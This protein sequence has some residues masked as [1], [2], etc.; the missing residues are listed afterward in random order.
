MVF[1]L[2]CKTKRQLIKCSAYVLIAFVFLVKFF[3]PQF[4]AWV[5]PFLLMRTQRNIDWGIYVGMHGSTYLEYPIFWGLRYSLTPPYFYIAVMA[6]LIF[7]A[8]A[9][10]ST[11]FSL[12]NDCSISSLKKGTLDLI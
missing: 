12:K 9:L 5:S 6:R 7:I 2:P 8:L 1:F 10:A 11:L 3:S 4:I